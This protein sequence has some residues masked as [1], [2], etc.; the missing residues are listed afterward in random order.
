MG[1]I[2]ATGYAP[3]ASDQPTTH[4]RIAHANNWLTGTVN[5]STT[6]AAYFA[7]AP[8]N[9]MTY[10]KWKPTALPATWELNFGASKT[11][12]YCCIAAHNM[13]TNGNSLQVQRYN[14]GAWS[15]MIP[16]T[17][18]TDDMPIMVIF[19][20]TADTRYRIR[21]SGGT[22]PTIGVIRFGQA[23]QMPRPIYGGVAPFDLAR[24]TAFKANVSETGEFLGRSK[25]RSH[26]NVVF[27]WQHIAASWVRSNWRS[28]QLAVEEEPF[29]ITWRPSTFS[30]V[31]YAQALQNP[32]ASNMGVRDLMAL[33]LSARGYGYD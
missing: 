29:F 23:M 12:D 1:V 21:I 8:D 32:T 6:D 2:F 25:I 22:L 7:E 31:A 4:A 19:A 14:A 5:A 27:N 11:V 16:T 28:F 10:E 30:E 20:G 9:S 13:G 33:G 18:I 15:D 24:Q 3:G 17:A 26:F